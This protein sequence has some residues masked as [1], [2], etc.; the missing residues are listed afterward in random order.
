MERK[1]VEERLRRARVEFLK[2]DRLLL[3]LRVN[4]RSMTHKFAGYLQREFPDWD[5]DC[6]YNRKFDAPKRVAWK[7]VPIDDENAQTVFPDIIVHRRRESINLLVLEAKKSGLDDADDRAKLGAFMGND[8][9]YEF[10]VLLRFVTEGE[11]D[12]LWEY[13]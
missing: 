3:E 2:W 1:D 12:V 11:G 5:V 4:E 7:R 9:Q 10:G 6:E 13:I 8:F